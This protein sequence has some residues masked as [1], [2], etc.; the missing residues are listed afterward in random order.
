MEYKQTSLAL[1]ARG[2]TLWWWLGILTC[3]I[4]IVWDVVS[5]NE[6]NRFNLSIHL[7]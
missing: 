5:T 7:F 3:G 4:S 1:V 2:L 6:P